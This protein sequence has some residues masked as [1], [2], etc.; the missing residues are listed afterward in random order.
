[1]QKI[2]GGLW[3]SCR[4]PVSLGIGNPIAI[5]IRVTNTLPLINIY[6]VKKIFPFVDI[7]LLVEMPFDI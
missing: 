1:M 2:S 7:D 5:A 6:H 3:Q 4:C